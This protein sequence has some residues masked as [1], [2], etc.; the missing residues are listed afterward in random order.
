MARGIICDNDFFVS[1]LFTIFAEGSCY[2]VITDL[3]YRKTKA[4][5]APITNFVFLLHLFE[6]TDKTCK[7]ME[8]F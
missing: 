6:G 7:K 3:C 4:I 5:A 2:V 1:L 8:N